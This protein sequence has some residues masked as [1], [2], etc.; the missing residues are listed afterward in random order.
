M[1]SVTIL[2]AV[3]VALL[4]GPPPDRPSCRGP[5]TRGA[6]VSCALA[7]HPSVRAAEFGR[8]AVEGRK[9]AA[10]TLL[11]SNPQVEVTV[12]Q[13]VGMWAP[14]QRD[15]NVYGRLSQEIEIAGQRRKR[16]AV[17][18]AEMVQAQ[19]RIELTQRDIA[20]S[21]LTAYFE[22]IAAQDQRAMIGRISKTA[23]TLVE[24]ARTS[25]SAGLGS[26]LTAD[27]AVAASVRVQRQRVE[28]D[29]RVAVASAVLA[30]LLGQDPAVAAVTVQGDLTPLP[31]P[32]EVA[33]L[34]DAALFKRA[35][36]ELAKSEREVFL[37][38]AEL[39]RRA[40]VPNPS[41]VL[42]AQRD[43][44]A[45]RVLG[46]GIAFPITLPSPLGRSFAG[47]IAENKALA[48]RAEAE[49]ERWRRTVRTEVVVGYQDYQARRAELALFEGDRLQRA[50]AHLEA[51]GQEMTSG[52]MS[53][54]EAVILQQTFLE[55]LG[56]HIE[57]RRALAL[58]SVEL[59]R[60]AG[61][62][63]EGSQP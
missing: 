55:Y 32:A 25:E 18:D 51:L 35:E 47:E 44:F 6:V 2:V 10:R 5:L 46:G 53:I 27:V 59:A 20:A 54:R 48:R 30:G 40:R 7:E 31:M 21:A 24:L 12:A 22:L 16:M 1:P 45:E 28:A 38:Q 56:T 37:R 3:A 29:R 63:P 26:A 34:V 9:Q 23:E 33:A 42:Y 41:V 52:R 14:N 58:A 13:R 15:T 60:V 50:E 57:A 19:A 61:L 8:E 43:G 17:A 36:I 62:L 11:P 49:V 39:Y 4:A